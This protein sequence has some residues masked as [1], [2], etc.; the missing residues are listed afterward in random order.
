M[1]LALVVVVIVVQFQNYLYQAK[2]R[3]VETAITL[4]GNSYS[5]FISSTLFVILS[6]ILNRIFWRVA[7][8]LNDVQ[9]HR[10]ETDYED[11]FVVKLFMFQFVNSYF[12]PSFIA[13]VKQYY[14]KYDCIQHSCVAELQEVMLVLTFLPILIHCVEEVIIGKVRCTIESALT[15]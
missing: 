3:S 4:A 11:S 14:T 5:N 13:F 9:N 2:G 10:T 15:T 6:Q 7:L 8:K 12:Y 1:G